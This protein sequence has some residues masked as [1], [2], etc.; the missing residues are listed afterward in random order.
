ML[1]FQ[2][3][4]HHYAKQMHLLPACS[5]E[6]ITLP[7]MQGSLEAEESG[8]STTCWSEYSMNPYLSAQLYIELTDHKTHHG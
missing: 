3:L 8:Q 1:I 2:D 6:L 7:S 5:K 4:K